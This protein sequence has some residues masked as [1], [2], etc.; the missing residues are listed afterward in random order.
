VTSERF[1]SPSEPSAEPAEHR[2]LAADAPVQSG[3]YG[4]M[5]LHPTASGPEI[6][7]VYRTLSR[8]YHP[9]TTL[10]PVRIA[11][12]KFQQLNE[13][14]ATLSNPDR[15]AAYDRTLTAVPIGPPVP[16]PAVVL[17]VD[18]ADRPLSAGELFAL[19]ILGLTFVACLIL[20]LTLGWAQGQ[21]WWQAQPPVPSEVGLPLS[22]QPQT[23][24]PPARPGPSA[25]L[26]SAN[27][28]RA[29][30][31]PSPTQAYPL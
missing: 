25:R 9:D 26:H 12:R 5:G 16:A 15:R 29:P 17:P 13:A 21:A 24:L 30:Q 19:L 22:N 10:L 27:A 7:Q 8:Q 2:R 31:I 28:Q 4:L 20:A 1:A 14:Y 6:H 3:Y 18:A 23:K 11:T